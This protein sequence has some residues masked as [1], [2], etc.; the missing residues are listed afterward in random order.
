MEF[1][2]DFQNTIDLKQFLEDVRKCEHEVYFESTEGDRLALRSALS[3]FILFSICN[4]PELLEGAVI[5]VCGEHDR[6][7]L[8]PYFT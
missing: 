5:C 4:K 8:L 3:Q 1:T 6:E 2:F 7:L